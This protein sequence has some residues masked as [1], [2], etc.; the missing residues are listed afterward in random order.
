MEVYDF[1]CSWRKWIGHLHKWRGSSSRGRW[2]ISLTQEELGQ[3][4]E[5]HCWF[6]HGSTCTTSVFPKDTKRD[7]WFLDQAIWREEHKSEDDFKKLVEECEDP[8]CRDHTVIL[9]KGLSNQRTTW[10]S[11]GRSEECR[12]GDIHLE[13]PPRIM[14]FI[15][16]RNVCKKEVITFS[17]LWEEEEARLMIRE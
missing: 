6:N 7:V 16:S 17:W 5:D 9:Y 13:W 1:T 2:G 3:D 15:H 10:S 11:K 12:S 4:Q 8:E 14:E